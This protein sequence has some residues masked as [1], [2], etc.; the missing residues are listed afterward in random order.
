MRV[1][2]GKWMPQGVLNAMNL[3]LAHYY[4]GWPPGEPKIEEVRI[5]RL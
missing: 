3:R 5:V 1:N 4:N 2:V